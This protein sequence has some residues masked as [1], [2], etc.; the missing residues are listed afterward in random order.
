MATEGTGRG[1]GV[2]GE[3]PYAASMD[4]KFNIHV[5]GTIQVPLLKEHRF[6]TAIPV[7]KVTLQ[8]IPNDFHSPLVGVGGNNDALYSCAATCETL[9]SNVWR[10]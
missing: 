5:I 2:S 3:N 8:C 6:K 4:E 1:G 9:Q 10:W 7:Q